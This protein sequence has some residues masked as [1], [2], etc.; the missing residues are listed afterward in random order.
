M[1]WKTIYQGLCLVGVAILSYRFFCLRFGPPKKLSRPKG[2]TRGVHLHQ[3]H[4]I[5]K[6]AETDID[7]IAIHG[8][9]TKSPDTWEYANRDNPKKPKVNWLQDPLM[10]PSEVGKARIFMCDWPAEMFETSD[11]AQKKI[12]EIARLLV[13]GIKQRPMSGRDRQDRPIL[14]IA[15]CLG[16]IILMKALTDTSHDDPVRS[17]TRGVVFL[18]T[19]F[20][21]TS[22]QDIARWAEPGLTALA[23]LRGRKMTTLLDNVKGPTFELNR[24][25]GSFTELYQERSYLVFTFYELGYTSLY[26]KVLPK[27]IC[28]LFPTKQ[29]RYGI[30]AV[31]HGRWLT[32]VSSST[33]FPE[34]FL[35][36]G[37]HCHLIVPT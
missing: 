29:V 37:I 17:A 24:L 3:V 32:L 22:F 20:G 31:L 1:D 21:G 34:L 23:W 26:S 7:I 11:L 19:P 36:S 18:S 30:L 4:P 5:H 35:L 12:E 13:A 10:L 2:T 14:F 15:S 9:D 33:N 6:D 8:L 28:K 25:V 16:G 27:I